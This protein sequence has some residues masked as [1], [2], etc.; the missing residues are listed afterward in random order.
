MIMNFTYMLEFVVLRD[1][2]EVFPVSSSS[3]ARTT[4]R[5]NRAR[6]HSGGTTRPED[7]MGSQTVYSESDISHPILAYR[8]WNNNTQAQARRFPALTALEPEFSV[9]FGSK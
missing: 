2:V 1:V 7:E 8:S 6:N 5:K 4:T 3:F 9:I